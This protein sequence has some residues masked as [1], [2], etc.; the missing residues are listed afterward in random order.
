MAGEQRPNYYGHISAL[1]ALV[2]L[3]TPVAKAWFNPEL[4]SVADAKR[5]MDEEVAAMSRLAFQQPLQESVIFDEP[6]R[7]RYALKI[8]SDESMIQQRRYSDGHEAYRFVPSLQIDRHDKRAWYGLPVVHAAAQA[9]NCERYGHQGTPRIDKFSE[10]GS[11]VRVRASWDDGC[12]AEW[13]YDTTTGA[14]SAPRF[15]KCLH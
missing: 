5:R 9:N 2:A 4:I 15:I 3:A 10:A 12:I 14:Q 8:F 11:R 7:G 1:I 6:T 13:F